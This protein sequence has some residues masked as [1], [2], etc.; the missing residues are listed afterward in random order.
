[1]GDIYGTTTGGAVTSR[2]RPH[3]VG[4]NGC[5]HGFV[6]PPNTRLAGWGGVGRGGAAPLGCGDE[7]EDDEGGAY[8]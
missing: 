7:G 3:A 4:D 5:P 6:L 1:M 2:R 8:P